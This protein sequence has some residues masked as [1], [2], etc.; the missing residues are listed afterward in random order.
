MASLIRNQAAA[1]WGSTLGKARTVGSREAAKN[2]SLAKLAV[3]RWN[4]LSGQP[5]DA[6]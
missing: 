5:L 4:H 6:S 2:G 3:A 1:F